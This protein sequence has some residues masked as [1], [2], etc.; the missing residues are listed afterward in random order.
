MLR[1]TLRR[2]WT[3]FAAWRHSRLVLRTTQALLALGILGLLA[4][5]LKGVAW[6]TLRTELPVNPLFYLLFAMFYVWLPLS[7]MVAYRVIWPLHAWKSLPIFI[8]KR[9]YNREIFQYSGEVFFFTWARRQVDRPSLDIARDIRDQNI[10]SSAASTLVALVLVVAFLSL[11]R[12]SLT[13]WIGPRGMPL[14]IAGTVVTLGLVAVGIRFRRHIFAMAPG[15]ALVIFGVHAARFAL[16]QAVQ[17]AMWAVAI[18]EVPLRVWCSYA[19][20]SLVISRLPLV[21]NRDLLFASIGITLA[22]GMA[23]P[24][25]QVAALMLVVAGLGK[26]ATILLFAGSTLASR[27]AS[28]WRSNREGRHLRI[29]TREISA[30][31]PGSTCGGTV[32]VT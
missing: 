18:P 21:T 22:A 30:L 7:E 4:Y 5:S 10:V 9:I 16:E 25:E 28:T 1:N 2:H 32:E 26:V 29:L 11:S 19:A 20:L 15:T 17:I 14:L 12:T 6:S 31:A 3:A 8:K 24:V 13:A 27:C 23:V